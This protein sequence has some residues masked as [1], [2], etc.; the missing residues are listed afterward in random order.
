MDRKSQQTELKI[1]GKDIKFVTVNMLNM[2]LRS[3]NLSENK[4]L[5]L[6]EEIG[7]LKDLEELKIDNNNLK[8]LPD[9]L[10]KI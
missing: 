7:D 9:T 4:I 6:P 2:N 10:G 3:I 5:Y 8:K 1:I